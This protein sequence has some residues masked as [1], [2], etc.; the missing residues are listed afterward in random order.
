MSSF[1]YDKEEL[2]PEDFRLLRLY[3]GSQYPLRYELIKSKLAL[4]EEYIVLS[5]TWGSK[6]TP[7]DITMNG[8]K[9]E[10]TKNAY[11]TLQDLRS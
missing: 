10:V 9:M 5:Y 6:D 2:G 3:K 8:M 11:L 4:L 7:C 1:K